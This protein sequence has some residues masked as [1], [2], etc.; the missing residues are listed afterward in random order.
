MLAKRTRIIYPMKTLKVIFFFK[1]GINI[2]EIEIL[3]RC[4]VKKTHKNTTPVLMV[5]Y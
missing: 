5:V 4:Y 2:C 1:D 3:Q